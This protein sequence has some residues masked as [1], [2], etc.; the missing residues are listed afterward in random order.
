MTP[1]K[2]ITNKYLGL[3]NRCVLLSR[4]PSAHAR[5]LPQVVVIGAQKA[6]TTSL[7]DYMAVHP[8]LEEGLYKELH[9]FDTRF[10]HWGET[11]YRT[12]FPKVSDPNVKTFETTPRYLAD[13]RVPKR[14]AGMLPDAK[15]IAVLRNPTERAISHYFHALRHGEDTLPIQ[16]A[17]DAEEQRL[18]AIIENQDFDN[19]QFGYHSYKYR[20]LYKQQLDRFLEHYDRSKLL[21]L[22][23]E[24]FFAEPAEHL[25]CVFEF[26]D[27]DPDFVVKDLKPKNTG[28]NRQDVDAS[29]R[30]YLDDYFRP[31]NQ[32]L[33]EL[34]G[35][36]LN[37]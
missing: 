23:S 35:E 15:L 11:W 36:D 22:S 5:P 28:S 29:V 6:G 20:G 14:M 37:W 18:A 16:E 12:F 34:L 27:V 7:H 1:G 4:R 32:A 3:K 13:P 8:Q 2:L 9:F 26:I 33:Y 31:H 25:R 17:F 24:R 10:Y 21:V 30:A 19:C